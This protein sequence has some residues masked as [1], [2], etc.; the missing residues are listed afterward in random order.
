MCGWE[1]LSNERTPFVPVTWVIEMQESQQRNDCFLR[2]ISYLEPIDATTPDSLE[3]TY[4]KHLR[5]SE[6]S[7][8]SSRSPQE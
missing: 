7:S 1:Y 5:K 2:S 6:K 3:S 4:H 8:R